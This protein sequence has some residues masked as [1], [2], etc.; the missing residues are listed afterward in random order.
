M[1]INLETKHRNSIQSY[2]TKE[3]Q[4]Q[5]KRYCGNLIVGQEAIVSPWNIVD[6]SELTETSL[7]PLLELNP[8]IILIGH[9]AINKYPPG[10]LISYLANRKIGLECMSIGAACR[11]FNVLL[12]ESREVVLGIIF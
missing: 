7:M 5:D 3:V 1:Q 8:K 6:V 2:G 9:N 12:G 10:S 4:I 11:T